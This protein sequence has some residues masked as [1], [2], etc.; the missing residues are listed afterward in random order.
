MA[1]SQIAAV[2]QYQACAYRI[3]PLDDDCTILKVSDVASAIVGTG[4]IRANMSVEVKEG[5]EVEATTA[6]GSIAWLARDVDRIKRWN[7][8]FEI[9][10]WDYE[11]LAYMVGGDLITGNG[12]TETS[13]NTK[14]IGWAAPGP[15]SNEQ[16]AVALEIWSRAAYSTGVCATPTGAPPTYI[17]HIFPRC[18][19]QLQDRAFEE[20]TPAY[21]KFSGRA[22]ANP[23]LL[24]DLKDAAVA[25]TPWIGPATVTP[26]EEATY[27]QMFAEGLPVSD[28]TGFDG[29]TTEYDFAP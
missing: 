22:E 28:N 26:F 9:A 19:F 24:T 27:I 14:T 10:T 2:G 8:E 4:I 12:A 21:M 11:A 23:K 20:A 15:T 13:W 17:R 3:W 29:G 18:T 1:T 16:P 6:C 7:L 5:Q 25:D